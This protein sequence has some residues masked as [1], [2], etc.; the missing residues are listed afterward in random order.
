MALTAND[1]LNDQRKGEMKSLRLKWFEG[2]CV[3]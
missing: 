3:C 2:S 1:P